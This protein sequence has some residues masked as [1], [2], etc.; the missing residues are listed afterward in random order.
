MVLN[1]EIAEAFG[2]V[3]AGEGDGHETVSG[4]R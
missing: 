3:P 1:Q 4:K 2:A